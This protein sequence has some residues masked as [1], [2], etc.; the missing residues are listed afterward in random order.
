MGFGFRTLVGIGLTLFSGLA[1]AQGPA[2]TVAERLGYPANARL[3][4]LHADDFGVAHSQ[5]RATMEALEHRWVTSASIMVPCPWFPEVAAWAKQ[6]PEADLGIHLTLNAEWRPYRWRGASPQ[7]KDSGLL[8]PDGFLPLTSQ[9]V[10]QRAKPKEVETEARAQVDQALAAGIHLTHVDTHMLTVVFSPELLR[11]YLETGRRYHLPVLLEKRGMAPVNGLMSF[12]DS[13]IPVDS[14]PFDG[15]LGI[16]PGVETSGWLD[17]YKKLLAPQGPGVYMLM[18]HLAY[19]DEE[20]R[21]ITAG[22]KDWGSKW[23]QNDFDMVRSAEFQAFLKEQG[24]ILVGWR[25]L[26]KAMPA[27]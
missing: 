1:L 13:K 27:P 17:A 25:D 3:L 18:L 26:L 10:V 15:V 6:H 2:K 4:M 11:V 21:G 9:E 14:V 22:Q 19:D 5:N 16:S 8:D 23:R 24:F 12:Y 20:M 7:P